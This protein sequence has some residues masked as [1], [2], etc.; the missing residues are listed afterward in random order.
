MSVDHALKRSRSLA[1]TPSIAAITMIGNGMLK[2]ATTSIFPGSGRPSSSPSAISTICG[3]MRSTWRGVKALF[4]S[5]RIRVCAGGSV[6]SIVGVVPSGPE[7]RRWLSSAC[8][9]GLFALSRSD[10]KFAWSFSVVSTSS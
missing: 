2:S 9:S 3:R 4:T 8:T 1:G 5:D 10:E 6:L 7:A